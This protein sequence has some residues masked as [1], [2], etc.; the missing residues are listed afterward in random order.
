MIL[1]LLA[2]LASCGNDNKT[3]KNNG[4][5]GF[6][7]LGT[8]GTYGGT[9]IGYNGYS[10]QRVIAENPCIS[11][12]QKI[13]YTTSAMVNSVISNGDVWV[14]VTSFGDVAAVGGTTQGPIAQIFLCP[15]SMMSG[16]QTPLQ[17]I[18][19][20]PY[21]G[22]GFKQMNAKLAL[23]DGTVANFRA[24][25]YGNSAGARFSYCR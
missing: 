10:L 11:G 12:T 25:D 16:S 24:M 8:Y 2:V 17:A 4:A 6:N 13:T 23:P 15:R 21:T 14:G 18:T 9:S 19:L 5:Y 1:F 7:A 3:G 22:C 20:L